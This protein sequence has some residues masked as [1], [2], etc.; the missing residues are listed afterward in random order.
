[1]AVGPAAVMRDELAALGFPSWWIV[2]KAGV[3][4]VAIFVWVAGQCWWSGK[5]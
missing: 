4:I 1:M 3:I 5:R 2:L